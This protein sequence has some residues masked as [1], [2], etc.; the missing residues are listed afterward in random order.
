MTNYT[1]RNFKTD[2]SAVEEN[3]YELETEALRD[4]M[5]QAGESEEYIEMVLSNPRLRAA[6]LLGVKANLKSDTARDARSGTQGLSNGRTPEEFKF[7]GDSAAEARRDAATE[8][9]RSKVYRDKYG[10]PI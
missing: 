7:T 2:I 9:S 4:A 1:L 3:Q 5:S 8:I 10:F 6:K